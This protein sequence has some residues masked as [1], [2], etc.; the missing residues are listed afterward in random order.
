MFAFFLRDPS[1]QQGRNIAGMT[2]RFMTCLPEGITSDQKQ[3]IRGILVRFRMNANAGKVTA[4]NQEE[5]ANDL[6]NYTS[7]G[8]ISMEELRRFMAKVG[9]YTYRTDPD[10]N[11]PEGEV[12]H[13]LLYPEQADD[14]TS[15]TTDER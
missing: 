2:D 10:Y 1:K 3:E 5:I 6:E 13:P 15:T 12:D 7:I 4:L 11:L 9:Y 14:T 8:S